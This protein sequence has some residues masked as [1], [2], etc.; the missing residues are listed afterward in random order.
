MDIK[1]LPCSTQTCL[2]RKSPINGGF[3]VKQFRKIN[4][5]TG[6]DQQND[7]L[8][9]ISKKNKKT[10]ITSPSNFGIS[11]LAKRR[12]KWKTYTFCGMTPS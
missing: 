6:F 7:D 5:R 4:Y 11:C 12:W 10:H 2:A 3:N 9:N 1:V 8:K